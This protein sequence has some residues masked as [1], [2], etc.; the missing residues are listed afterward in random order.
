MIGTVLFASLQSHLEMTL[1]YRDDIESLGYMLLY[2]EKKG[3]LPWSGLI[4]TSLKDSTDL[5]SKYEQIK[6]EKEKFLSFE[7]DFKMNKFKCL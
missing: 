4:S 6:A 1:S 5:R 2:M 3:K 7:F